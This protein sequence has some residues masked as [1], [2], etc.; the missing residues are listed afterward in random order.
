[1][2][3][4]IQ[5]RRGPSSEWLL[6]DPIL[7]EGE[8]GFETD[9]KRVKVGDGQSIWSSLE[10]VADVIGASANLIDYVDEK[11]DELLGMPP[12]TL[13]TLGEL[14]D[15]INNDPNFFSNISQE[16]LS[17]SAY[18]LSEANDYTDI[19]I[20]TL[21]IEVASASA[22][23]VLEANFYTDSEIV[24]SINTA[25]TAAVFESNNYTDT[26]LLDYLTESSAS[27]TYAL[28]EELP[29]SSVLPLLEGN[30]GKYLTTDGSAPF[31][32][33]ISASSVYLNIVEIQENEYVLQNS[34][35][36]SVIEM[37]SASANTIV[38]PLDSTINFD[39]GTSINIIQVGTGQTQILPDT[40]VV[41]K[42]RDNANKI[43]TQYGA[44]TL[45]KRGT[46][47]WILVG[48]L[49]T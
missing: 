44:A 45:Y 28:K 22:Q 42:S 30:E 26:R 6:V 8:I 3:S 14:A 2:A 31:W 21:G 25:S 13:D 48:D 32:S 9:T 27:T 16:I 18:S 19:E 1:M 41:I 23:A 15:A 12:E 33:D 38:V 34:S 46:N 7:S 5:I 17:A 47:E 24:N 40:G 10:Y 49:V 20:A 36:N 43:F 29:T 35:E 4:K 11:V 37:N 39:I